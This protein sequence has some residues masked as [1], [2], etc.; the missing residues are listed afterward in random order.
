[1]RNVCLHI[2]ETEPITNRTPVAS[3][4]WKSPFEAIHNEILRYAH[5]HPYGCKAYPLIKNTPRLQ[6]LDPRAHI[7]HL[8]GYDSSNIYRIW[9]PSLNKVMIRSR[10]V[11]FNDKLFYDPKDLDAGHILRNEP[12][13][14]IRLLDIPQTTG[15]GTNH[16]RMKRYWMKC[17]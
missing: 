12:Q 14:I 15:F 17:G 3:L 11:T 13:T 1:M 10:E 16:Q 6:K 9:I 8:V 7:G 4:G 2:E 5:M